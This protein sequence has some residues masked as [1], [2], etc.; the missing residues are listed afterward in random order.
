MKGETAHERQAGKTVVSGAWESLYHDADG[1]LSTQR[2]KRKRAAQRTKRKA[3]G[4]TDE[5]ESWRLSGQKEGLSAQR[6]KRK[7]S[8][9]TVPWNS[10]T[11][12]WTP[13][14]AA[15]GALLSVQREEAGTATVAT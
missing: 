2:T 3:G 6:E 12:A 7:L 1:G 8:R 11:K 4:S 10:M 5:A 13:L 14:T 15:T 9:V